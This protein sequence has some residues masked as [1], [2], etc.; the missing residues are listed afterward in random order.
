MKSIR[1]TAWETDDQDT[2]TEHSVRAIL[3]DV[4]KEGGREGGGG[5]GIKQERFGK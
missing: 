5:G 4:P 1:F 2:D 3:A